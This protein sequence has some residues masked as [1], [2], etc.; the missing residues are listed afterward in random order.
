MS[1][2]FII[3]LMVAGLLLL[4]AEV[5][6]PGGVLGTVGAVAMLSAVIAGFFYNQVV[7]L[8]LLISGIVVG[9]FAFWAWLKFFPRTPAGK[10]LILQTDEHDWKGFEAGNEELLGKEGVSHTTLRPAGAALI[11][12]RRINVETQGEMIRRGHRVRVVEVEGNRVV[13]A[14]ITEKDENV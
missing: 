9:L 5:F 10:R 13:V 3:A 8:A 4:L 7:G 11:D 2:D 12:G 14:E 6:V 1:L